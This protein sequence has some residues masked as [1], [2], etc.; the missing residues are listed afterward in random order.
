MGFYGVDADTAF[1]V[2]TRCS[3]HSNIKLHLVA[4]GLIAAASQP[5]EPPHASLRVFINEMP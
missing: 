5:S 4:A 1:T 2:L 3:Q